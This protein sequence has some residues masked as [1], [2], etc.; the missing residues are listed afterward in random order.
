MTNAIPAVSTS[1]LSKSYGDAVVLHSL[2]LEVPQGEVFGFLAITA[3]E[4][5]R[6]S[7][8]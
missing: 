6:R 1:G 7:A 5:P 4:R 3:R 2:T 8:C